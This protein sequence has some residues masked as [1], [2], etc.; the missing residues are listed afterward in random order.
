MAGKRKKTTKHVTT[1]ELARMVSS[2]QQQLSIVL[3]R[4][5]HVNANVTGIRA[6]QS[7]APRNES[8]MP[9][10]PERL[11]RFA[12][13]AAYISRHTAGGF[14]DSA[15]LKQP[16]SRA[17]VQPGITATNGDLTVS[18]VAAWDRI[19]QLEAAVAR[20]SRQYTELRQRVI[21]LEFPKAPR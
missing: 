21:N 14:H 16:E 6:D 15:R 11:R 4:V 20:T 18:L 13:E 5:D 8:A 9:G 7:A 10:S 12:E 3:S 2:V 17:A 1:L 19:D